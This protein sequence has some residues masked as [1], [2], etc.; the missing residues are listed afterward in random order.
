MTPLHALILFAAGFLASGVNA[1]AGGGSLIS[2]PILV[3]LGIPPLPANATNSVALWPGS[4]TGA[5]GFA[6]VLPATKGYLKWLL[7]PTVLGSIAGAFLLV[8][9]SQ[10]V[11]DWLV[12]FL[13]A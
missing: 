7:A 9:T 8:S 13:I 1:V 6:N 3:A 10:K 11:F 5:F 4:L 2:F 12:P